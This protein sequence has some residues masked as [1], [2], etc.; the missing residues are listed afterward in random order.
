MAPISTSRRRMAVPI[1]SRATAGTIPYRAA[2]GQAAS[3]RLNRNDHMRSGAGHER[4]TGRLVRLRARLRGAEEA[5]QAGHPEL[6]VS[7][8]A[9]PRDGQLDTAHAGQLER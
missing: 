5:Q 1:G 9:G 2:P 7:E 6:P 4:L 3:G 8:A